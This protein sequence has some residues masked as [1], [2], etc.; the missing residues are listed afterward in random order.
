[1]DEIIMPAI[2]FFF[3]G[4]CCLIP[5]MPRIILK[6]A[7]I[8]TIIY[9]IIVAVNNAVLISGSM[10]HKHAKKKTKNEMKLSGYDAMPNHSEREHG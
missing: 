8:A 5:I 1:M 9:I 4:L 2:D 6:T 3:F 10:R 7:S